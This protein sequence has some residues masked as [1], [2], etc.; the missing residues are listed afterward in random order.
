[1]RYFTP[2]WFEVCST[3]LLLWKFYNCLIKFVRKF[4][5]TFDLDITSYLLASQ[6]WVSKNS[7]CKVSSLWSWNTG[8]PTSKKPNRMG[9]QK[10][11]IYRLLQSELLEPCQTEFIWL[12]GH[13]QRTKAKGR[14]SSIKAEEDISVNKSRRVQHAGSNAR[15]LCQSTIA[16]HIDF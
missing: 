14:N 15:A 11:H 4:R 7:K 8:L 3:T 5:F 12:L 2:I 13:Y 9:S 10:Y 16:Y 6:R 1:M